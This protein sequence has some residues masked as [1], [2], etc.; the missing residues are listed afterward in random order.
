M[1]WNTA[2]CPVCCNPPNVALN[3]SEVFRNTRDLSQFVYVSTIQGQRPNYTYQYKSQ[4]ERLQTLM[5]RVNNPQ[6]RA[7]RNNGGVGCQCTSVGSVTGISVNGAEIQYVDPN[8]IIP[9]TWNAV[10]GATGYTF[11]TD[12]PE[13]SVVVSGTSATITS[14][15]IFGVEFTYNVTITATN[16]CSTSTASNSFTAPCFLAGSLVA[17]SDGSSKAI[18]DVQVGDVV[19]GAFGELNTILALHRPLLGENTMT[20]INKEHSTTSH[21]PHISIDKKFYSNT[22]TTTTE[23][24]YGRHHN[25]LDAD[26]CIVSMFLHGLKKERINQLHEGVE[27]KTT[28]GSRV[29]NTL[30][31]Y[32][33]PPETQLYNLVVGGS[34]T[35]HVDGYAVTGWPREDDFDYDAWK[36]ISSSN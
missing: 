32:S 17:M 16:S 20:K 36:P 31:T 25:V 3:A 10:P 22:P 7:M 2:I 34:H 28:D 12:Y 8:W 23:A 29:V 27:L 21:H 5:G 19:L 33:L 13:S 18:E 4:T 6:A 26:G 1:A 30:E 14:P 15:Y 24:T 9:V 11:T 35:Y